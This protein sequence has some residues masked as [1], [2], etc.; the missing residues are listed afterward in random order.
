MDDVAFP[1][2]VSL[3]IVFQVRNSVRPMHLF[4]H[5]FDHD[6]YFELPHEGERDTQSITRCFT[7]HHRLFRAFPRT[8]RTFSTARNP[9]PCAS[10][11]TSAPPAFAPS[12]PWRF[13]VL[14]AALGG[15]TYSAIPAGYALSPAPLPLTGNATVSCLVS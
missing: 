14:A 11:S 6:Y 1:T 3:V 9:I 4:G 15:N 2:V 7:S 13:S 10:S 5:T 8:N 12:P